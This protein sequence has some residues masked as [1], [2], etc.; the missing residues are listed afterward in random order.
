[1]EPFWLVEVLGRCVSK[2]R[3]GQRA[4]RRLPRSEE[5]AESAG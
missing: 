2:N 1:M 3:Y 4:S 5:V